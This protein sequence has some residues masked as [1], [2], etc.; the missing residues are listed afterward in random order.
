MVGRAPIQLSVEKATAYDEL[1]LLEVKPRLSER[2]TSMTATLPRD[3]RFS[4]PTT[5][6]ARKTTA[7]TWS[8]QVQVVPREPPVTLMATLATEDHPA[9]V[10]TAPGAPASAVT[11]GGADRAAR[12]TALHRAASAGVRPA[13]TPATAPTLTT[14]DDPAAVVTD[15]LRS[16]GSSSG[17]ESAN[18]AVTAPLFSPR[19]LGAAAKVGAA[20]WQAVWRD[21]IST[22]T[23][24]RNSALSFPRRAPSQQQVVSP[25]LKAEL[26]ETG[27][28]PSSEAATPS[29]YTSDS[30]NGGC[31]GAVWVVRHGERIDSVE[32]GWKKTAA[33]P[34]DP[35]L[36]PAGFEQA[37]ATGR[38]L[39]GHRLDAIYTSPFLRCVQTATAIVEAMGPG[40]PPIHLEPGLGEWLFNRW[41]STMP[42]DGEMATA[43]LQ[44]AHGST[45]DAATHQPIWDSDE[46]RAVMREGGGWE[47]PYQR[48]AFPES[49]PQV[50]GRYTS[51]LEA[52]REAA[53]YALLVTHGF[54]VQAMA[55]HASEG[56]DI[57]DPAYCSLTRMR[58]LGG[59]DWSCDLIC[60]ADHLAGLAGG[61]GGT[62][63]KG[64]GGGGPMRTIAFSAASF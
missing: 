7:H 37:A 16:T 59:E 6:T 3:F 31:S 29:C 44:Q 54:G 64:S 20:R 8:P 24:T 38:A 60:R 9:A 5:S 2:G 15:V 48:L 39:R 52:L 51:T 13:P 58:R 53:P 19:K 32:K 22:V 56:K 1:H 25:E 50:S 57:D 12:S 55:E 30:D 41:F 36:T 42:V 26:K 34:H 18:S 14:E 61:A 49:L 23:S 33:R 28:G 62:A 27:G 11:R 35:P 40:A 43:A 45:L 17:R 21:A 4:M 47:Q 46:R 63:A 10:V